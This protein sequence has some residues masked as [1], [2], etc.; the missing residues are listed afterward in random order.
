[1]KSPHKDGGGMLREILLHQ[2]VN[3][4]VDSA[5]CANEG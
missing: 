3:V 5:G 2:R 4:W 1:M